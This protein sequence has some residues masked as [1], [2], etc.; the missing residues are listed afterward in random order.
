MGVWWQHVLHDITHHFWSLVQMVGAEKAGALWRAKG[1]KFLCS[2]ANQSLL[3]HI[4]DTST[5]AAVAMC[6]CAW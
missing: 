3:P 1:V 5:N 2:S 4:G 6:Q